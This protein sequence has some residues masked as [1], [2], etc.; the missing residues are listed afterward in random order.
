MLL[1]P[2]SP[3]A[4]PAVTQ[5]KE[6]LSIA[7]RFISLSSSRMRCHLTAELAVTA[8]SGRFYQSLDLKA[9]S[10]HRASGNLN[11]SSVIVIRELTGRSGGVYDI[12]PVLYACSG[13]VIRLPYVSEPIDKCVSSSAGYKYSSTCLSC[14]AFRVKPME[15]S[16]N[17]MLIITWVID[18]RNCV[19][20]SPEYQITPN[21]SFAHSISSW[22]KHSAY[23]ITPLSDKRCVRLNRYL[24]WFL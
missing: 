17:I 19:Q 14:V 13:A 2:I 1:S 21:T 18:I 8:A 16:V 20:N 15:A 3:S 10:T 7:W 22:I 9:S 4:H 23:T 5:V 11:Q 24:P 6:N 12:A